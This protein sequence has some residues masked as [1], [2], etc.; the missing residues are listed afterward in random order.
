M[1]TTQVWQIDYEMTSP[2]G[3]ITLAVLR[4]SAPLAQVATRKADPGT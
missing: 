2:P 1:T 4:R 3:A